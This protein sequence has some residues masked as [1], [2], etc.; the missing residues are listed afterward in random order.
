MSHKTAEPA[1][2]AVKSILITQ[3]RPENDKS[4]YLDIAAEWKIK[5]DFRAFTHVEGVEA[6]DFRKDKVYLEQY[7]AVIITSRNAIEHYFRICE[8]MRVKVS[9]DTKYFCTSEAIALYL[10]KFIQYRK[11]KIF[12]GDGK[13]QK[14]ADL[15]NKHKADTKFLLPCSDVRDSAFPELLKQNGVDFTEATIFRTVASDL[16][17]LSDVKYD[18]LVFFSPSSV[19]SLYKNF[20][21]FVQGETRIAAFGS[22]TIEALKPY[23]L[24]INVTAPTPEAPSMG[25]AIT[26]YLKQSNKK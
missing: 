7:P 17:D 21:D 5:V 11:R 3:P 26:Q 10:Q 16:S 6:K 14:L 2:K 22:S 23:G 20:P 25:M 9:E 19:A 15:I 8:E 24:T 13:P 1:L 12:F 18:M 4:P